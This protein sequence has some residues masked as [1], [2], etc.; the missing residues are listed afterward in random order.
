MRISIHGKDFRPTT[1]DQQYVT[2][3]LSKLDRFI[4][5]IQ[6]IG[7]ELDVDHNVTKGKKF[8]IEVWVS[9]VSQDIKAGVKAEHFQEAVDLV[10]PKLERQL[11]NLKERRLDR[12]KPWATKAKQHARPS[13]R[14][15]VSGL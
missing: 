8:R 15:N 1:A 14:R 11:S 7:V 9:L 13:R 6:R 4:P 10:Y 3:K 5:N 12:R 2:E